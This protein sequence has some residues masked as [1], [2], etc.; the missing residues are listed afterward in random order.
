ML[1]IWILSFVISLVVSSTG[2]E[3]PGPSIPAL[4]F[5]ATIITG[6]YLLLRPWIRGGSTISDR[7]NHL[8]NWDM[9]RPAAIRRIHRIVAVPLLLFI[10]IAVSIA[11]IGGPESQLVIIPI[12]VLL[13]FLSITGLY[14]LLTPW[15]SRLRAN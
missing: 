9:A 3:L 4:S 11:A 10:I 5:I 14:M 1:S 8:K 6:S 13:L 15:A 7:L 2:G 12:V